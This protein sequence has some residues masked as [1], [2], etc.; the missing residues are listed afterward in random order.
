MHNILKCLAILVAFAISMLYAVALDKYDAALFWL[1]VS[2]FL[3]WLN[4]E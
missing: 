2:A 1:A 4:E 3:A